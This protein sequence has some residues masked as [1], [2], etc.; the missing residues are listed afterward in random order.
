MKNEI[1]LD[2][3]SNQEITDALNY[4]MHNYD[5]IAEHAFEN[6]G[7]LFYDRI[8]GNKLTLE[9]EIHPEI[10]NYSELAFFMKAAEN[11]N[12]IGQVLKYIQLVIEKNKNKSI[13][14]NDEIQ[15][16]LSAGFALA[17]TDKKYVTNFIDL[18]R[19]FDMDHEVYEPFFI[20]LLLNKWE[21]CNEILLLLAARSGSITGQWGIEDY[22]IPSLT[23]EQKKIFVKYLFEDILNTKA[24]FPELL[25]NALEFL[26][27]SVNN[28]KFESYF[29][30]HKPLYNKSNIPD[31]NDIN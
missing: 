14:M 24:V 28:Q 2:F 7:I 18:L 25:I 22:E 6:S 3:S 30:H 16:G 26:S 10:P 12:N 27:I 29:E 31:L 21:I 11:E 20:E 1:N 4:L 17:Y 19:T 15:M 9:S 13:W 8:T 23:D 5:E